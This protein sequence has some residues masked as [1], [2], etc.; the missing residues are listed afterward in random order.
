MLV[1]ANGH[2]TWYKFYQVKFFIYRQKT[3]YE[4]GTGD[5]SSD[6]CSS[7]LTLNLLLVLSE[8]STAEADEG[9]SSNMFCECV[10]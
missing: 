5:W 2:N 1:S 10:Q 4:F 7:D 6:V 8:K 9:R 3:A